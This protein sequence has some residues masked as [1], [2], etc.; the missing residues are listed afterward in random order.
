MERCTPTA[1]T[2]EKNGRGSGTDS[3]TSLT[4]TRMVV[5][6]VANAVINAATHTWRTSQACR[7]PGRGNLPILLAQ[8]L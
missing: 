6:M 2:L 5:D 1:I 3:S 7:A 8:A 4:A